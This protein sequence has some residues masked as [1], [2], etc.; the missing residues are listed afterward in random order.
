VTPVAG[1]ATA[2]VTRRR[3][4]PGPETWRIAGLAVGLVGMLV[5]LLLLRPG[6]FSIDNARV[7]GLQMASTGIIAVGMA[8]LMISGN[9]DLSIGS[10]YGLTAIV[11]ASW[12]LSSP[13]LIAF[14][15][16]IAVGGAVGL[17]N[18]VLVW[19]IRISPIIITLAALAIVR[20][21]TLIY[22]QGAGVSRV[23]ADF[24]AVANASLLGIPLPIL[25]LAIVAILGQLILSYTTVGIHI[26]A[27]GG[28]REAAHSIGVKVRRIV[29]AL[30]VLNGVLTALAASLAASRFGAANPGFGVGLELDVITAV[31]LGGVAFAGGE[32][33]VTGVILAV[34]L[35]TVVNSGIVALGINPYLDN[36]VKGSA[37]LIAVGLDQVVHEQRERMR[38]VIAMREAA[39][40]ESQAD[41]Q[42]SGG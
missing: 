41:E 30:F 26:F 27:V 11:A 21:I 37:L 5:L 4:Q 33:S 38:T 32:G 8:L 36:V 9:I 14:V 35:L 17:I 3:L 39:A 25:A 10:L 13:P 1:P 6:Y 22:T 29:L 12:A 24:K 20:G 18:G 15:A 19:R 28:N 31:I 40:A 23:P 16:A 7:I 2:A 42:R 34:A